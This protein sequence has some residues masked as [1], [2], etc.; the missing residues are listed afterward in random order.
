MRL[1]CLQRHSC[2]SI[3]GYI[4]SVVCADSVSFSIA[5]LCTLLCVCCICK[6]SYACYSLAMRPFVCLFSRSLARYAPSS[7]SVVLYVHVVVRANVRRAPC[8]AAPCRR[9]SSAREPLAPTRLQSPVCTNRPR[10]ESEDKLV[11]RVELSSRERQESVR[12]TP[13]ITSREIT[14]KDHATCKLVM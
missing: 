5:H 9:R 12:K 3:T 6:F 14:I 4:V 10:S 2:L 7:L 13:G 11:R 8:A 1:L